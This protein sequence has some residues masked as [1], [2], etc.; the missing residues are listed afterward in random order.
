MG[1]TSARGSQTSLRAKRTSPPAS[2]AAGKAASEDRTLPDPRLPGSATPP[3]LTGEAD[4]PFGAE[5]DPSLPEAARS[6]RARPSSEGRPRSKRQGARPVPTL[7]D[8]PHEATG[9]ASGQRARVVVALGRDDTTPRTTQADEKA[10]QEAKL[11]DDFSFEGQ[12]HLAKVVEFFDG[13]TIRVVFHLGKQLVQFRARMDGYDSPRLRPPPSE[14]RAQ[15]RTAAL[16]ARRALAMK[17]GTSLVW[18]DCGPFDAYGRLL[19][20]V[21]A[22]AVDSSDDNGE[23]INLWMIS[24][25]YGLPHKEKWGASPP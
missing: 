22:R 20:T 16:L 11:G 13:D 14:R 5:N 23:N 6:T 4:L 24:E 7:W 2:P 19:V 3:P 9:P 1:N 8:A 21:Y 18:L 15:E 25:G 12:R 17:I 10:L